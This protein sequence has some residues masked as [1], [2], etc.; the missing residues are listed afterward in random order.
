[1]AIDVIATGLPALEAIAG[2][3]SNAAMAA[4]RQMTR[5]AH[6]FFPKV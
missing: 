3:Q 2:K 5:E 1:M 6:K 4:L